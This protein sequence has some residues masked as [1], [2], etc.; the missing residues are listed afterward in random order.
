[1]FLATQIA[2]RRYRRATPDDQIS[3]RL[4]KELSVSILETQPTREAFD[5]ALFALVGAEPPTPKE[6]DESVLY[7]STSTTP[8]LRPVRSQRR[9]GQK[10]VRR[11]QGFKKPR[12]RR[13]YQFPQPRWNFKGH[14]SFRS[15]VFAW[16][17]K[18]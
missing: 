14:K 1:M 9:P 17:V 15:R 13:E 8:A 2:W 10:R 4:F 7:G 5:A 12:Q 18:I 6:C 16:A 11:V 3:G